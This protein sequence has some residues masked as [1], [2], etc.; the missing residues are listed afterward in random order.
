MEFS[1][2]PSDTADA[3]ISSCSS[4]FSLSAV[5]GTCPRNARARAVPAR[6]HFGAPCVRGLA[7]STRRLG[8]R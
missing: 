8:C 2:A 6:V 1:D 3:T 5:N 4:N 7:P